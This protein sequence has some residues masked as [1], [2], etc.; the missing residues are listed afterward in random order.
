M[1]KLTRAEAVSKRAGTICLMVVNNLRI[2]C[3]K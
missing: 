1:R 3:F 2:I